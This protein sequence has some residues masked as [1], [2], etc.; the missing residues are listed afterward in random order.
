MVGLGRTQI[1]HA[2]CAIEG[3]ADRE[4]VAL[5]CSQRLDDLANGWMCNSLA[6]GF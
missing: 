3:E 6:T 1:Q 4:V 2:V 5:R